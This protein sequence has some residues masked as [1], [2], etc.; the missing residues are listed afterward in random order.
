MNP[1]PFTC[2]PWTARH[3]RTAVGIFDCHGVIV[4][5]VE[6]TRIDKQRVA[7]A[8][9]SLPALIPAVERAHEYLRGLCDTFEAS[10]TGSVEELQEL[11]EL[12]SILRDIEAAADIANCKVGGKA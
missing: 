4:A 7:S 6:P 3:M 1:S 9:A 11:E 10:N 2:R 12:R 8:I 5:K